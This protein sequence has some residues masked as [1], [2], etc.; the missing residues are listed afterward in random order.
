MAMLDCFNKIEELENL[1]IKAEQKIKSDSS[2]LVKLQMG[3]N[4][5]SSFFNTK[6]KP[7]Q[8]NRLEAGINQG[9]IDVNNYH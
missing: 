1:I 8:I 2:S 7:E 5:L 9:Q 4:S 3:K 6:S